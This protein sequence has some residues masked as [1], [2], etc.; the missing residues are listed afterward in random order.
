MGLLDAK[1]G[2]HLVRYGISADQRYLTGEFLGT[3]DAAAINGNMVAHIPAAL[4]QFLGDRAT[5]A[6]VK[7]FIID[8][9]THAFQHDPS[10]ICTTVE[11]EEGAETQPKASIRKMSDAFGEPVA[12]RAGTEAVL[13]SDFND[14]GLRDAFCQRVVSFQL[15]TIN[16]QA[17]E[18]KFMKY[19]RHIGIDGMV[20]DVVIAPYFWMT[21]AT[22]GEWQPINRAFI[23]SAAKHARGASVWAQLVIT[24]D[25]LLSKERRDALA[26]EYGSSTC[27]GVLIWV[28]QF[29]EHD[30]SYE[31]LSAFAQFA[32][33]LSKTYTKRVI[34]L[35]GGYFSILLCQLPE[36]GVLQGVCHGLEYGE[37]RSVVPVGGGLPMSKFYLPAYHR[38]LRFGDAVRAIQKLGGFD[39]VDRY[40]EII[41]DCVTCREVITG[42]PSEDFAAYGNTT[43]IQFKRG[44]QVVTL[45]YPTKETK[46]LCL[47]HYLHNK[48]KEFEASKVA[49]AIDASQELEK[50]YEG[51]ARLLGAGEAAYLKDWPRVVRGLTARSS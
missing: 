48:R 27:Q 29:S 1:S 49:T 44:D 35:Y 42:N 22:V 20:P 16:N 31:H 23:E 18:K 7:P 24:Q 26:K 21:P 8:P 39:S 3:Y 25:L 30:A 50:H 5:Q 12:S 19:L 37:D 6:Q 9:L 32:Q 17:Q 51:A 38:R 41:C 10:K 43:P 46:D 28:D 40:H 2:L 15:D 13:P 11:T 14:P 33:A 34:N 45:N 47:R 36:V 4:A